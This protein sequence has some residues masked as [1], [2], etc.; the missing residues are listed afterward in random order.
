MFQSVVMLLEALDVFDCRCY[1]CLRCAGFH[2]WVLHHSVAYYYVVA[3]FDV[4]DL[5]VDV[6]GAVELVS[7]VDGD[8]VGEYVHNVF[9]GGIGELVGSGDGDGLVG[10][11][12]RRHHIDRWFG[13]GVCRYAHGDHSHSWGGR[14]S[15]NVRACLCWLIVLMSY[16][17]GN[18]NDAGWP[19]VVVVVVDGVAVVVGDRYNLDYMV[20]ALC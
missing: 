19:R 5:W 12:D 7:V 8:D 20:I 2:L 13:A 18:G 9:V 16:D 6:V 3:S 17:S 4:N 14:S 15:L 1:Y 11:A 10:F